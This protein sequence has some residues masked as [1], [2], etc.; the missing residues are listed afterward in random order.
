V[1]SENHVSRK[2]VPLL[3]CFTRSEGKDSI[4]ALFSTARELATC[5]GYPGMTIL[6]SGMDHSQAACNA[7]TEAGSRYVVDCSVHVARGMEKNR[8]RLKD[9]EYIKVIREHLKMLVGITCREIFDRGMSICLTAW[10]AHGEEDYPEWFDK[11]CIF[12]YC[13]AVIYCCATLYY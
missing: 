3:H 1:F 6:A 10:R 13:C 12:V 4:G 2:P 11:V 5:F 8:G 7:A 9:P